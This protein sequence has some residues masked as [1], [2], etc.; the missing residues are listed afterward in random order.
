MKIIIL[1][2]LCILVA[3]G[4]G[5]FMYLASLASGYANQQNNFGAEKVFLI[6]FVVV[7]ILSIIL[8]HGDIRRATFWAAAPLIIFV[9]GVVGIW[10]Y[11]IAVKSD[12][13]KIEEQSKNPS[14]IEVEKK[15]A[16]LS[17]DYICKV[18]QYSH[19]E[20]RFIHHNKQYNVL[21]TVSVENDSVYNLLVYPLGK[22]NGTKLEV[23]DKQRADKDIHEL[24]DCLDSNGKTIY[25]NYTLVYTGEQDRKD[26]HLDD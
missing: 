23:Y 24:N 6:I 20:E 5:V 1:N 10:V 8:S 18:P 7:T 22:I 14:K 13:A 11:G 26:Y 12:N 21:T 17:K 9:I 16:T 2:I 3:I 4:F 15:L 25:D 19:I